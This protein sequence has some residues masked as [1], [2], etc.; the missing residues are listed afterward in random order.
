MKISTC[1]MAM[2]LLACSV[3]L[4]AQ[5]GMSS[6]SSMSKSD[7]M[8]KK[9]TMTGCIGEKDG[10][11]MLMD[12]KHPDGIELMSSEDLKAHVGHK[13]RVTGMMEKNAMSGD[14]MKSDDKMSDD[15]M[16]MSG[17]KVTSMKMV[18]E[19]CTMPDAMMKK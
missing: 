9:M 6:D 14:N 11:Y 15:K 13:V 5:T 2:T 18:S 10:K 3:S 19:Q 4:V 8:G 16:G 17:F 12:K 7:S 1:L